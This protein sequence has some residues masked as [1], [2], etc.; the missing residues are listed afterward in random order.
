MNAESSRVLQATAWIE[1]ENQVV[2]GVFPL[3]RLLH[4]SNHGAVFLTGH[5]TDKSSDA[6]IK[7]LAADMLQADA[8]VAQWGTAAALSHPYLVRLFDAGR[9]QLG[10]RAFVFVVMEYAEQTLGEI[11]PR[12]PLSPDEAREML[13]PALDALGFLHRKHLA[14]A[15]V[16]PSN[17]MVVNDQLK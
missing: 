4:G 9:C 7:L 17:I 13:L 11:L 8:Q 16:K 15:A 14:H 1:W 10:G 5:K 6:A 2:N 3:R 12:R